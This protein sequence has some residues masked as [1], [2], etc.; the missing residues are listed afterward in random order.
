LPKSGT[1]KMHFDWAT[2]DCLDSDWNR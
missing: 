1:V 2:P